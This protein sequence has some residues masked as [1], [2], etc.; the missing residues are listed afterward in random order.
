MEELSQT[1]RLVALGANVVRTMTE[2]MIQALDHISADLTPCPSILSEV[3]ETFG[4]MPTSEWDLL[5]NGDSYVPR[6]NEG[7]EC[8]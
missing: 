8:K 5:D 6:D 2:E 1:M 7:G 4:V 3:A